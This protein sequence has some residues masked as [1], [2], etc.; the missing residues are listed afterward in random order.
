MKKYDTENQ[1]LITLVLKFNKSYFSF[2]RLGIAPHDHRL[3]LTNIVG[4]NY[5]DRL[6]HGKLKSFLLSLSSNWLGELLSLQKAQ[7]Q[8]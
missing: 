6:G 5:P 3:V 2:V 1:T 4:D 7:S 8:S